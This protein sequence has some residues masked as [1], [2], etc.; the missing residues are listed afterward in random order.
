MQMHTD[1]IQPGWTA[2]DRA[3]E[4]IGEVEDV[5]SG[6]L[7]VSKGLIFVK[8][9]YIPTDFI[10]EVDP[11]DASVHIDVD[12]SQIDSQGWD[13]PPLGD[14]GPLA[15]SALDTDAATATATGR[16]TSDEESIRVP[17]HEEELVAQRTRQQAGEVA[18]G[19]DVVE[20]RVGLDVPVT[21]EEVEVTRR[22]VDR[23]ATSS[24]AAFTDSGGTIRVPV[25]AED[26]AV[27]KEARVVEEVEISKAPVTET[28]HV[29][30][31]VRREEV[32]VEESG[33]ALAGSTADIDRDRPRT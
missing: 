27:S 6:Y 25:M 32:R 23:A 21:R 20:E 4:K 30:D 22:P 10:S 17:V 28:R 33:D 13:Q 2:L 19:K 12:K 8:D 14:S 9:V 31:T 15:A 16:P 7:L 11:D 24:D 3:N 5:G 29:E 18:V 1:Q 26:V